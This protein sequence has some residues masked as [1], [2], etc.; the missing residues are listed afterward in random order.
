MRGLLIKEFYMVIKKCKIYFLVS[1]FIII[2]TYLDIT[3][4][5]LMFF[6][7]ILC[8][9]IPVN[10]VAYDERSRWDKYCEVMPYTRAQMVSVKYITGLVIQIVVGLAVIFVS[11]VYNN[12]THWWRDMD[13]GY[14]MVEVIVITA[15]SSLCMPFIFK[16]G[17]EKGRVACYILAGIMLIF[18]YYISK[19][20]SNFVIPLG[21][22]VFLG[23]LGIILYMLSW[24]LSIKFYERRIV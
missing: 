18:S 3:N 19:Y 20:N 24:I 2:L 5:F 11:S 10:L 8:S 1:L 7:I 6:P 22:L 17:A 13:I 4:S 21:S 14:L 16:F 12:M 15:F 23:V 9:I